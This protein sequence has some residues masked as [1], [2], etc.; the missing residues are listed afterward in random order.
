MD[1]AGIGQ[2]WVPSGSFT[3]GTDAATI[4]ALTVAAPP[5]WVVTEFPSEVPAHTVQLTHGYWID[6]DEVTNEAFAAFKAAGGYTNRALWSDAGWTWLS[7]RVVGNLPLTCVGDAPTL[8]RLCVTWFEAEA[9]AT[10]RGGRLP[11]EAE[12][13]Y[14][15]RGPESRVYPWGETFDAAK[16]NV[17]DSTGPVPVASYPTGASWVGALDMS[18]NAMEWVA[19][20]LD[21]AYY[22]SSPASDPT[23][24][25][26]RHDQG[27]E[28]RLVGEQRVRRAVRV[29]A[30]RGS[31]DLPGPPHRLPDRHAMT[32]SP[33]RI[34]VAM[35][36][37][38]FS[39]EPDNPLLDDEILNLARASR[40]RHRPR[41]CF[42][43]TA[44]G[45]S[46]A[47]VA[48]F[49]AAFAR[50]T[51]AD[52]L[53]LFNRTVDDIEGLLL[54]QDVI[55]VGG[56]NTE[57][58]L[59]V[60]RVHGV[61]RA[62][63]RAWE[64]GVVMAGLS[65]GSLCWFEGGTTDSF[66][67][68]LAPVVGRARPAARQP[69]PALRRRGDPTRPLPAA[70]RRGRPARRLCGRRR[71]RARLPWH[72][73]GRGGHVATGGAWLPGRA[74]RGGRGGRDRAAGALPRLRAA[75]RSRAPGLLQDAIGRHRPAT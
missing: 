68:G 23:G 40:G 39:M 37:G 72:G 64:S 32:V 22:A 25:V 58:M 56:G 42:I 43:P 31:A 71:R 27:R 65:A 46:L 44:S 19:D 26:D 9:Y 47:Y 7:H 73:A 53:A 69:R 70:D 4:S 60:W 59:A 30:L 10:W 54:H 20:W 35:G 2:V 36:G 48:E 49:Y 66:G 74:R 34:I 3:M 21:P 17:V 67:V 38:G 28:G 16:A 41:I 62:L 52:H 63:R 57:N 51:D 1:P 33:E 6:T 18:G 11:T 8:P 5:S 12:W 75:V 13:E 61:D 15:A 45:D 55:Y 14:A 29:P 24:P 50:R